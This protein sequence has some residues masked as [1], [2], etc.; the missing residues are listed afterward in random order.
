M[1]NKLSIGIFDSGIGGL[2]VAKQI[3]NLL[4]NENIIY[5]GDTARVPYGS[6]GKEI[7]TQFAKELT[8]FLLKQNVKLIVVACNTISATCLD[9]LKPLSPVPMLGVQYPLLR[10]VIQESIGKNVTIIDSA[11]PT[12]EQTKQTLIDLKLLNE[13]IKTKDK[14]YI[15]DS[16]DKV[17]KIV[18]LFFN[19]L[20]NSQIVKIDL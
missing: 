9:E 20:D 17:H 15:T 3:V 10:K 4:P 7:I 2:T 5:L 11:V 13:G 18:K 14:I 12:A 6:R 1:M 19:N 16:P 8:N